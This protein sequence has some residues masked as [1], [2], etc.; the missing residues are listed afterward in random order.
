MMGRPH[1][2]QASWRPPRHLSSE[3]LLRWM[4]FFWASILWMV[5][6]RD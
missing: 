2:S 1:R 3:Q 5:L 6:F 4:L